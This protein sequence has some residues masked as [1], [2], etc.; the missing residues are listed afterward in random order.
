MHFV[1]VYRFEDGIRHRFKFKQQRF[2]QSY[3]RCWFD[4]NELDQFLKMPPWVTT[5][6]HANVNVKDG[7][8]VA[9]MARSRKM[10]WQIVRNSCHLRILRY[11]ETQVELERLQLP[12]WLIPSFFMYY[13]VAFHVR[14]ITYWFL[15]CKTITGFDC[16][17]NNIE[18]VCSLQPAWWPHW[19]LFL[20]PLFSPP[21]FS[22]DL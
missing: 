22:P 1:C 20:L 7:K 6:H 13:V 12:N 15:V 10:N 3:S 18:M 16:L 19:I 9:M 8:R 5:F 4:N 11:Q 17:E 2:E 21:H 14:N